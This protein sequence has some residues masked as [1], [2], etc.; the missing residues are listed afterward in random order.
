MVGGEHQVLIRE[1]RITPVQH[2]NDICALHALDRR[3]NMRGERVAGI[4]RSEVAPVSHFEKARHR[5]A[6]RRCHERRCVGVHPAQEIEI[7]GALP[8]P[9]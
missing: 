8:Y 4:N 3:L 1:I 6:H 9:A 7:V 2:A 5:G